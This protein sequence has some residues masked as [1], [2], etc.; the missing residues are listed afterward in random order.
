MGV[1]RSA[2]LPAQL[3][4]TSVDLSATA[5]V[6]SALAVFV[7]VALAGYRRRADTCANAAVALAAI[8][9]SAIVLVFF[10]VDTLCND[11]GTF[12]AT[13]A[14]GVLAIVLD[15]IRKRHR[16]AA[17]RGSAATDRPT[18]AVKGRPGSACFR[19]YRGLLLGTSARGRWGRIDATVIGVSV[20]AG[21]A[22]T[23][24]SLRR[25]SLAS[26]RSGQRWR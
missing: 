5:S 12:V 11:T 15:F 23:P 6:G 8:A 2:R 25:R 4:R 19:G 22:P 1:R 13:L 9:V 3:P 7:S 14:I 26:S 16:P 24:Q 20:R 10:A 18:Q 17:G 21:H